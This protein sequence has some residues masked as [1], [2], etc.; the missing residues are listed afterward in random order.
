[1]TIRDEPPNAGK[2]S[3]TGTK[4]YES[5][6]G[7]RGIGHSMKDGVL[8]RSGT[9]GPDAELEMGDRDGMKMRPTTTDTFPADENVDEPGAVVAPS[10]PPAPI[11]GPGL[12]PAV[13]LNLDSDYS[14]AHDYDYDISNDNNEDNEIR[15]IT[16]G[17]EG[18]C[19]LPDS[20]KMVNSRLGRTSTNLTPPPS[21]L[22]LPLPSP[23]SP[24]APRSPPCT[25]PTS[26]TTP[27]TGYPIPISRTVTDGSSGT[28]HH[29]LEFTL[30]ATG[31]GHRTPPTREGSPSRFVRFVDHVDGESGNAGN[32]SGNGGRKVLV[33]EI[34]PPIPYY[35]DERS[36]GVSSVEEDTETLSSAD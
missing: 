29:R 8:R 14:G 22:A 25:A 35:E 15:E 13:N 34:P 20:R 36:L 31:Q 27:S 33:V 32:G 7:V 18:R 5:N 24:P 26:S 30:G 23:H 4:L 6:R 21:V 19:V 10:V 16:G 3:W 11:S 12:V 17:R 9:R 2:A 28:R 1:M